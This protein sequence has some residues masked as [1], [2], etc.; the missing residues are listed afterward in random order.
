L[1]LEHLEE[2]CCP[3]TSGFKVTDL[4]TLGG[5][6]TSSYANGINA[7]GQV[8]GMSGNGSAVDAF[9]W[10]PT[11]P[12]ATTG[13]MIDLHTLG[14]SNSSPTPASEAYGINDYG[15]VVGEAKTASEDYHAF[16][17][18]PTARHGTSSTGMIDLGT[19]GGADSI[20]YG[21]NT[22]G[23]VVGVSDT[24]SGAYHAFLWT[25]TAAQ[26][27]TGSMIDLETLGGLDSTAAGIND[28]G[29]VC[30]TADTATGPSHAFLWTPTAPQATTGSMIDLG[31]LGGSNSRAYAINTSG[32]VAGQADTTSGKFTE[33]H[34]FRWTPSSSNGTKGKMKDL[35]TL[36]S[37]LTTKDSAAYGI[38]DSGYVVGNSGDGNP[39]QSAFYWPGTGS[40]QNLNDLVPAGSM[41]LDTAAGINKIGQIAGYDPEG[42]NP[43]AWLLTPTSAAATTAK[44]LAAPLTSSSLASAAQIGS[45][46]ASSDPVTSGSKLTLTA[47]NITDAT[48]GAT[49]TQV[50]FY[51]FDGSGTKH[52]LGYGTPS[53]TGAWTLTFTV[54]LGPGIY[55]LDAQA[56]DS[57]GS[58]SDPLTLTLTVL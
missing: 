1:C 31:T 15:Q 12:Q 20:A 5:I 25:P 24:A 52:V 26:A 23:Q 30:G 28:A 50:A 18:T 13:G 14:G 58:L 51:Y 21:I 45:F 48:P 7:Y 22:Q 56:Q 37:I 3:S 17:W 4:G 10:T 54:N 57:S 34:A 47:S 32:Q 38:N 6:N 43:H 40:L 11:A 8:V 19:L 29:Q 55:T 46:T 16:L 44:T 41:F 35:G 49:I 53:G 42:G 2:R 39:P 27:T 9:L 36:N 33:F